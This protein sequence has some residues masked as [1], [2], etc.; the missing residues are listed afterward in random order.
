MNA[1]LGKDIESNLGIID[2]QLGVLDEMVTK[3][4]F[5]A[6]ELKEG[7]GT[8]EKAFWLEQYLRFREQQAQAAIEFNRE[9]RVAPRSKEEQLIKLYRQNAGNPT[10]QAYLLDAFEELYDFTD[11]IRLQLR[12]LG[13]EL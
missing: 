12:Q 8:E 9:S 5:A 4:E 11:E 7:P 6:Q 3:G 13:A 1:N 2:E 10:E